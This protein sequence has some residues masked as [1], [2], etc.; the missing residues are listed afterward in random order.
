MVYQMEAVF[1]TMKEQKNTKRS[2]LPAN[3]C[4]EER[5]KEEMVCV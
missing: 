2:T 5:V 4:D 1:S 3:Q